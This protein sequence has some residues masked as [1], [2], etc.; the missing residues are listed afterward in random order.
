M[1]KTQRW[2]AVSAGTDTVRLLP[3]E[4]CGPDFFVKANAYDDLERTVRDLIT[5]HRAGIVMS[6]DK[7]GYVNHIN[8][9]AKLVE[10]QADQPT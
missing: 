6:S 10:M 2:L 5:A 1:T 8:K 3:M 9:L 4:G 7:T